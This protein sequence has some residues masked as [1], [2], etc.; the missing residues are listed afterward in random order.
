MIALDRQRVRAQIRHSLHHYWLLK[1]VLSGFNLGGES[2]GDWQEWPFTIIC[3]IAGLVLVVIQLW[4]LEF[5][6]GLHR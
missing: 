6:L 2:L 3:Y 4:S 1:G 5:G